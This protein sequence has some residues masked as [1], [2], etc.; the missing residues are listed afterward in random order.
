VWPGDSWGGKEKK[1]EKLSYKL[2]KWL[3]KNDKTKIC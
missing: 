3:E 2:L 1:R